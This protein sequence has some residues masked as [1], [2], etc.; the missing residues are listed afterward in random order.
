M[1]Q[2]WI[3]RHG[4]PE[5][6]EVREKPDPIP[7]EGQVRIRVRY[8]GVNFADILARMGLYPGSP[9]PPGVVGY[10]VSGEVDGEGP[11]G[12][13]SWT[14]KRVVALTRF[15]GYSSHVCVST[16]RLFEVPGTVSFRKAAAMPVTYLTAHLMLSRLACLEKDQTVLIHGAGGG[17]GLS[18]FQ[19]A[20]VRG[21]RCIGTASGW[22]HPSLRRMGLEDL[23]DY[24]REDFVRQTLEITDGR[25]VDVVLD[26]FGGPWAKKSYSCLA[27]LGKVVFYGLFSAY[28]GKTRNLPA[29]ALAVLRTRRFHPLKLMNQ[30]RG[31]L[32]CHLGHLWQERDKLREAMSELLAWAAEKRI[33]PVVDRVF[34]FEE[35]HSA[36]RYLQDRKNIGKVLLAPR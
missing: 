14:G 19:I 29:A 36:H 17:V 23:I 31:V 1:K 30:N 33:D 21:A 8:S 3:T 10:E 25:G 34:P 12:S 7:S 20:R 32:G 4:S 15:G 9:K 26:P 6:L 22:K 24:S 27:P 2:V 35:A 11:G 28:P 5:V 13:G 16:D 18:A